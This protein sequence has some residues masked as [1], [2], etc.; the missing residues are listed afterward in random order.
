MWIGVSC[1]GIAIPLSCTHPI[2]GWYNTLSFLCRPEY[3]WN[4]TSYTLNNNQSCKTPREPYFFRCRLQP[5]LTVCTLVYETNQK[6]DSPLGT[7]RNCVPRVWGMA[8]TCKDNLCHLII[9]NILEEVVDNGPLQGKLTPIYHP[10]I[11][12]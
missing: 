6:H 9:S 4:T 1:L 7:G 11:S 10:Q 12:F 5:F 8:R 2:P 3:S